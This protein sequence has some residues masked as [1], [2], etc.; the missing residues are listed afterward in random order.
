MVFK[1]YD[2][3]G[4]EVY[5]AVNQYSEV[6][7]HEITFDAA[8]LPSGIYFYHLKTNQSKIMGKM[9]YMR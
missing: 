4:N 6:V 7:D 2:V 3:I 9:V 8:D 1:V 5:N